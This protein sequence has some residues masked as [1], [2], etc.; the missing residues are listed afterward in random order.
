METAVRKK[1]LISKAVITGLTILLLGVVVTVQLAQADAI[2][3]ERMEKQKR[4]LEMRERERAEKK[5]AGQQNK[6]NQAKQERN[7][8]YAKKQLNEYKTATAL[9]DY[10]QNGKK[11]Y[12]NKDDRTKAES[13][14]AA[15]VE[16]WCN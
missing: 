12:L 15:D 16:K 1:G 14:A 2:S 10:D 5:Q 11:V 9:F 3:Q 8:E 7:C 4:Y 13:K 6:A